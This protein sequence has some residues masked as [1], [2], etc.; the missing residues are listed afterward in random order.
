MIPKIIHQIWIGPDKKPDIWINTWKNDYLQQNPDY[1]Y[2]FWGEEEIDNFPLK[3]KHIY[4]QSRFYNEKS[5]IARYEILKHYGGI[6]IDADSLWINKPNNSLDKI[7]DQSTSA[8]SAYEPMN[9]TIIANG[10]I[11]F[12]KDHIILNNM[13]DFIHNNYF[14]L[15]SKH[16][17]DRDVWR[18]TGT[19][20][21]TNIVN[22]FKLYTTIL[23]SYYFFPESFHQ[24]NLHLDIN[25]FPTKY[26][27]SIMF[28]Y[29]YTTNNLSKNKD[30]MKKYINDN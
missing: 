8:F 2:M 27:K 20:V 22:Q 10:V 6:F 26:P 18:V 3:N 24:N 23:P 7:L 14:H 19:E 5:D 9:K 1:Q 21:F 16:N 13:I 4:N 12:E 15:K 29:G 25:T 30:V 17:R 11:G 28:Q